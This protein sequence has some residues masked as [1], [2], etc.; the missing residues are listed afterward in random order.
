V[1]RAQIRCDEALVRHLAGELSP[2]RF[3]AL[4]AIGAN[5]GISQAALGGLLG[6]KGPGVVKVVDELER[7]GLVS[8]NTTTDRRIY[9]LQLTARGSADLRHYQATNQ[10]FERRIASRLSAQE[11][12]DLLVLLAKIAVDE[13]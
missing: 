13:G 7:L 6:I 3:A 10:D 5:P 4:C 1:K 11:R 2:A 12:A 8:R 9:A